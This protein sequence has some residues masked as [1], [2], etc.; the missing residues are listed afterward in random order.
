[1]LAPMTKAPSKYRHDPFSGVVHAVD[2]LRGAPGRSGSQCRYVLS[3]PPNG[4]WLFCD[5]KAASGSA[6]CE[7][8][9]SLCF[10]PKPQKGT[11]HGEAAEE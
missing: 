4:Y 6:Y 10:N 2:A 7:S 1:M 8:H 3:C 9:H 11:S 5:E